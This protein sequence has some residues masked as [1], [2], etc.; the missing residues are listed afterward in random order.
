MPTLT[1]REVPP[2]VLARLRRR[3]T[4]ERRSLSQEVIHLLDAALRAPMFSAAGQVD[5]WRSLGR[6]K[7]RR[8]GKQEIAAL[9][10]ARTKGRPVEL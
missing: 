6:W 10:K 7:S 5:A 8:T 1:I 2:D 9:Y 4:E 3:A